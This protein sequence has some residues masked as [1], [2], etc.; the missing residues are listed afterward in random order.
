MRF[1]VF[2]LEGSRSSF[3]YFGLNVNLYNDVYLVLVNF[4]VYNLRILK[5][6]S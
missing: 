6:G 2:F 1:C 5:Y 3:E 4:Y